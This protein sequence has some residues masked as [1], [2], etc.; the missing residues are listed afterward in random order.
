MKVNNV[1]NYKN[2]GKNL[3]RKKKLTILFDESKY[4]DFFINK[5]K[6]PSY[7]PNNEKNIKSIKVANPYRPLNYQAN[8]FNNSFALKNPKFS[9]ANT[10]Y[11]NKSFGNNSYHKKH[12]K[13]N[14]VECKNNV[15]GPY[16]NIYADDGG[17][18]K[19]LSSNIYQNHSVTNNN[20]NIIYLSKKEIRNLLG[21]DYLNKFINKGPEVNKS[22]VSNGRFKI[23][24]NKNPI[25][26]YRNFI[27]NT[28]GNNEINNIYKVTEKYGGDFSDNNFIKNGIEENNKN[29]I[30]PNQNEIMNDQN[31]DLVNNN[32]IKDDNDFNEKK[33]LYSI[34]NCINIFIEGIK[35]INKNYDEDY[36]EKISKNYSSDNFD[37]KSDNNNIK[38]NNDNNLNSII[39]LKK[40]PCITF[41][42]KN[43]T[44]RKFNKIEKGDNISMSYYPDKPQQNNFKNKDVLNDYFIISDHIEYIIN[45]KNDFEKNESKGKNNNQDEENNKKKENYNN[46][47][48]GKIQVLNN[49]EICSNLNEIEYINQKI[50]EEPKS[51]DICSNLLEFEIPGIPK[52]EENVI[53]KENDPKQYSIFSIQVEYQKQK[54]NEGENEKKNENKAIITQYDICSSQVEYLIPK[55]EKI[56]NNSICPNQIELTINSFKKIPNLIIRSNQIE[57][58]INKI[59][60][61][62]EEHQNLNIENNQTPTNKKQNNEINDNIQ[63][64]SLN[65]KKVNASLAKSVTFVEDNSRKLNDVLKIN[66]DDNNV[67]Q[68]NNISTIKDEKKGNNDKLPELNNFIKNESIPNNNNKSVSCDTR[69]KKANKRFLSFKKKYQQSEEGKEEEKNGPKKLNK[70]DI[71]AK[72]LQD[73][74]H[75]EQIDDKKEVEQKPATVVESEVNILIEN[76][77]V[78]GPKK[79][80]KRA[81]SF[82]DNNS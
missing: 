52:K 24:R 51:Y 41:G 14:S 47:N 5:T 64:P 8:S 3:A 16:H 43:E 6:K 59:E 53:N 56:N 72:L 1:G 28:N 35:K 23:L 9:P 77:P 54:L 65:T 40:Q 33:Q 18:C 70:I 22:K 60:K 21:D 39:Y 82:D 75:F 26:N 12:N 7:K 17:F 29:N 44:N 45:K 80:K 79:K 38:N 30:S 48:K 32:H 49:Y 4:K 34:D 31:S 50:N 61:P 67:N 42:I 55:I 68:S 36:K 73:K 66:R 81:I 19:R 11:T 27:N 13:L 10:I 2:N 71:F 76:K 57:Y 20:I 78:M 46:D 63:K 15:P 69:E 74:L 62:K 25:I 58:I 37:I